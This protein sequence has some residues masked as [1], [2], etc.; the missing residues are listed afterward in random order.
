[1]RKWFMYDHPVRRVPSQDRYDAPLLA[2]HLADGTQ[3]GLALC[4]ATTTKIV[5]LDAVP[6]GFVL[7]CCEC[8]ALSEGAI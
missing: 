1:M 7:A 5:V 2:A 3:P 4:G 6:R 8:L